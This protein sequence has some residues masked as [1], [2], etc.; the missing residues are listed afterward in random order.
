MIV[1]QGNVA[2]DV[3]RIL[4]SPVDSLRSSD[5]SDRALAILQSSRIKCVYC[6]GRRTL[7]DVSFTIKE[8][9]EITKVN[10]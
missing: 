1:G 7:S 4:L 8:F 5:I 2:I 6:I 9:R 3:A 10:F